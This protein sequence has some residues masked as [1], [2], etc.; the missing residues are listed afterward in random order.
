[1]PSGTRRRTSS[2]GIVAVVDFPPKRVAGVVSE[3]FVLGV[4]EEAVGTTLLVPTHRVND[5][6][7]IA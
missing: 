2:D 7:R 1:L 6:T 3:V 4:V 5:G